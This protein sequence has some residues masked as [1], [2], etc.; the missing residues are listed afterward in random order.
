[1]IICIGYKKNKISTERE[2]GRGN[3]RARVT[4]GSRNPKHGKRKALS[5]IV[6]IIIIDKKKQSDGNLFAVLLLDV[7]NLYDGFYQFSL[8]CN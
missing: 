5:V 7:N 3:K 8:L 2:S 4:R 6:S 1:V